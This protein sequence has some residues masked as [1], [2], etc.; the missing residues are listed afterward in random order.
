MIKNMG[1]IIGFISIL[2]IFLAIYLK[3]SGSNKKLVDTVFAIGFIG[4]TIFVF[5]LI[6]A[7][8]GD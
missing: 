5:A 4:T 2:L 3:I 7:T 6:M 1:Y 8:F